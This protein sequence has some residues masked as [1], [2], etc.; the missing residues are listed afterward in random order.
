MGK[1]LKHE[2]LRCSYHA[3]KNRDM[4]KNRYKA[5]NGKNK[6]ETRSNFSNNIYEKPT[7]EY[8]E[9]PYGF[10]YDFIAK[11]NYL[12]LNNMMFK[13]EDSKV[14]IDNKS[15]IVY[16]NKPCNEYDEVKEKSDL[17]FNS[18]KNFTF[19][20]NNEIV[21]LCHSEKHNVMVARERR[22]TYKQ[23]SGHR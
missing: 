15:R 8:C 3:D 14:Y 19:T 16:F 1:T 22:N 13:S 21:Y 2:K 5:F 7:R 18:Y 10:D 9:G 12:K 20:Y 11:N 23:F 4:M 6:T 17:N